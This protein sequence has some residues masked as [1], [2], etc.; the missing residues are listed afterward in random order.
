MITENAM[1]LAAGL[2]TRLR[3]I[4]DTIP[5]P[6]VRVAGKPLIDYALDL[7]TAAGCSRCAVNVHHLADQLI[8]HLARRKTP[9]III[10]DETQGLLNSGGGLVK[11]LKLL[12]EGPVFVMNADQF[13]I[14][15]KPDEPSNLQR[16]AGFFD[17]ERMDM[18]ML[19]VRIADTTGHDGKI[20]FNLSTDG[21]LTRYKPENEGE[22]VVYA[23]AMVLDSRLFRDAPEGPFNLNIYFDRAIAAGRLYGTILEGHWIT[24]GTPEAIGLAEAAIGERAGVS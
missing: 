13:W 19:C 12:P 14:G 20:D 21:R 1:V 23:G 15:E 8:D 3:P 7:L 9:E 6:L 5:K 24:V 17:P 18:A 16:L 22:G 11:G 4:T 2:G 10:S